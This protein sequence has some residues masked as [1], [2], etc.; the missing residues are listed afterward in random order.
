MSE[1]LHAAEEFDTDHKMR[2][3]ILGMEV[4]HE[5]AATL[6]LFAKKGTRD[7]GIGS[8]VYLAATTGQLW[9]PAGIILAELEFKPVGETAE[10][11]LVR[12]AVLDLAS[13]GDLD[14]ADG[15]NAR[16]GVLPKA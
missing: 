5:F 11:L 1:S 14:P 10:E 8:I 7:V 9:S 6:R 16:A 15:A 3:G 2:G 4:R 12:D 13:F